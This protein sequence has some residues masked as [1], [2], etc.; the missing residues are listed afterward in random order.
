MRIIIETDSM[1]RTEYNGQADKEARRNQALRSTIFD[2]TDLLLLG[3]S[4]L[5]AGAPQQPTI[6]GQPITPP[7]P[8]PVDHQARIV[9][10]ANGYAAGQE[11]PELGGDLAE[12]MA[13]TAPECLMEMA[14]LYWSELMA[15]AYERDEGEKPARTG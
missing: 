5:E 6:I 2:L 13:Y 7:S 8:P 15:D 12:L 4:M 14:P 9:A 10:F 1:V 11:R 3:K